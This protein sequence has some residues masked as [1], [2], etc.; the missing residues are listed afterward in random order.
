M[1]IIVYERIIF[2]VYVP[3]SR[4][5]RVSPPSQQVEEDEDNVQVDGESSAD[6]FLGTQ[7]IVHHPHQQLAVDHQELRSTRRRDVDE[8]FDLCDPP[9]GFY[10]HRIAQSSQQ[11]HLR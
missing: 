1:V 11:R 10:S 9:K 4:I 6:V 8:L 7:T 2:F 5:L 3:A